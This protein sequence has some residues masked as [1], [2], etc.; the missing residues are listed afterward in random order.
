MTQAKI[1][2]H[3]FELALE[4][5]LDL[6]EPG[7]TPSLLQKYLQLAEARPSPKT[8]PAIYSRLLRSAQNT[9]MRAGVVGRS[10]GGF[11]ALAPVLF[12]FRPR[13]VLGRYSDWEAILES[14]ETDLKPRG[15]IRRTQ[16]SIWPMF[17]RTILSAADFLTQFSTAQEFHNWV[18]FFDRDDRARPALPMLLMNE[19]YGLG[20]ATA[21]D[22]LKEIGYVKF[23]KP[24]VHLKDIFMELGL[25]DNRGDYHVLKAISRVARNA[26]T[27]PYSV[28]K[29]FWLVGS[30][31]FYD[32]PEIGRKGRIGGHKREF[33][34]VAREKLIES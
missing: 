29:V 3:A 8:L 2:R 6:N 22:F 19:I 25:C 23:G 11:D 30:G 4:F 1:D 20:F 16:R 13:K 5:L 15:K 26:N 34:A 32:D 31:Y 12:N 28:D 21:C 7:V 17:C 27:T 9:G 14:I 10:I 33:F 24:D 18:R